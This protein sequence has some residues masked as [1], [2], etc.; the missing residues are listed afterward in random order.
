MSRSLTLT[1][2]MKA[3]DKVRKIADELVLTKR[4]IR[5]R[6][7]KRIKSYKEE[8]RNRKS[9]IIKEKLFRALAFKRAKVV[10]FFV[11][12]GGEVNTKEMIQHSRELGKKI[13][14]PVCKEDKSMKPCVLGK[15]TKFTHGLY[16]IFEPEIKKFLSVENLDL[17]VV[18]G[19]AFDKRGNRL[20]RGKGY[21]DRFLARI[22]KKTKSIGLAYSFQIL[23]SVP[24]A[25]WDK[26]V[27]RVIFA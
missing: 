8:D 12:F 4:L 18:P 1:S 21:Y 6:I 22:P 17:V 25:G 23:P 15:N 11:S 3:M 26:K 14:V 24:T 16:E 19:L 10:M 13:A 7:L 20:G 27:D 2:T 9:A 5:S